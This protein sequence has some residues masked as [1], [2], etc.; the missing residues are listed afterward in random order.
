MARYAVD[1][2]DADEMIIQC[3]A[4]RTIL[5]GQQNIALN[6]LAR[7]RK[8]RRAVVAAWANFAI[9]AATSVQRDVWMWQRTQDWWDRV[10]GTWGQEQ[11]VSNFRMKRET[12]DMLCEWLSPRL[13]HEDTTFRQ[14]ISVQ[15]RV[16]V[17]LWWLATGAGYRTLAHLFGISDASVC[18]I[19]REFSHAVRDE[20]M[21]EYIKL[22]E[23]EELQTILLGFKNRWGFPQCAGAIDGS[24]IPI[25]APPENHSDYFN[26]KGWH[27]V[28]L[29]AVVDHKYC[30][31][32]INIG[33][34]GSVHDSRVLRNSILY[35]KAVRGVL[36]PKTTEEIQGT[37]V[38]IMLLG[39]PAYP[40]R[41][42]LMKGYP[43]TGNLTEDQRHFNKRLS[44]A[45][46]TVECAFGRLKGRWR[47][48]AKRLDVDISLV[49]T[50][51][52]TC[53]TLHNICEK[54]NEA[55]S[56]D[57]SAAGPPDV[58]AEAVDPLSSAADTQPLRICEALTQYF[59]E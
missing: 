15:K 57:S 7:R 53:C 16:E 12:F 59:A 17:G 2:M 46:M 19:V 3:F 54:H 18:L 32:N 31:S 45:R 34:P 9:I 48:L 24:H 22:P 50:I 26:R 6:A 56:E 21:R 47:C 5:K 28:I 8:K 51:I 40:L 38:P 39:D 35:E 41:S 36:F 42:W 20:M 30:L 44:G 52:S 4:F 58:P 11:W 55:Y 14:A 10:V 23:S 1:A 37:Q 25:I 43:E 33:W 13:S 29:Q 27:S 49:P